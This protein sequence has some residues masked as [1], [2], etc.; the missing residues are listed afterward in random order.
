MTT[1]RKSTKEK[2]EDLSP[3][4]EQIV[5]QTLEAEKEE[6]KPKKTAIVLDGSTASQL[7]LEDLKN[8]DKYPYVK[9]VETTEEDNPKKLIEWA[10]ENDINRLYFATSYE[11]YLKGENKTVLKLKELQ[12]EDPNLAKVEIVQ[13]WMGQP[14]AEIAKMAKDEGLAAE[15]EDEH[16]GK[17]QEAQ[18][19]GR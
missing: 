17:E 9:H 13:P 14:D 11:Q 8:K 19:E 7:L 18:E 15:E 3:E 12:R 16:D 1:K 10:T 6:N 5:K 4:E 2:E